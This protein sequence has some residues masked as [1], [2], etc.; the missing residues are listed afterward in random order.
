MAP[1][2]DDWAGIANKAADAVGVTKY[3]DMRV[4]VKAAV[5]Y[6]LEEFT[7]NVKVYENNVKVYETAK[8]RK[9]K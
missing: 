6:A 9:R 8:V 4:Y 3:S 1:V 2:H 5:L 7:N